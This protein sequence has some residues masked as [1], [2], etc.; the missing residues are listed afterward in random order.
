MQAIAS[1]SRFLV[2]ENDTVRARAIGVIHNVSAEV[3]A[4]PSLRES[5][6][7]APIIALL[8]DSAAEVC[9]AA[10]GSLQN[11][12]R[13]E[14]S[15]QFMLDHNVVPKLVSILLG[16]NIQSQVSFNISRTQIFYISCFRYVLSELS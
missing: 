3:S 8:G 6:C 15:R 16:C 4:I 2:S 12:S 14:E 11:I 9:Q 1:I 7:I 10:V 5:M 13:E